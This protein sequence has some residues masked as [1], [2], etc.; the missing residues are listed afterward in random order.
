MQG[1]RVLQALW[2]FFYVEWKTWEGFEQ[3]CEGQKEKTQGC[4]CTRPTSRRFKWRRSKIK[5][6]PGSNVPLHYACHCV[7]TEMGRGEFGDHS[8]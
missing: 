1:P 6:I 3:L 2:I 4:Y 7:A 5:V 8:G